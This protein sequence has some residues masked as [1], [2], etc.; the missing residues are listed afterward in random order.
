MRNVYLE[1]EMQ[2]LLQAILKN[3]F[4]IVIRNNAAEVVHAVCENESE[5][6]SVYGEVVANL[7]RSTIGPQQ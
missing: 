7:L 4:P 3:R 6:G 2:F 5:V 1:G